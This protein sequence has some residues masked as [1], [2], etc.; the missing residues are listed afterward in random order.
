MLDFFRMCF[1][2]TTPAT[3]NLAGAA[4]GAYIIH[5]I[6]LDIFTGIF[7]RIYETANDDTIVFVGSNT[8]STTELIDGEYWLWGGWAGLNCVTVCMSFLAAYLFRQYVPG[9]KKVL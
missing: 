9:A 8:P 3:A 4:Y 2:F 7:V 6:F 5:P 1:N